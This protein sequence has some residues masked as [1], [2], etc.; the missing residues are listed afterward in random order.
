MKKRFGSRLI[1]M[2]LTLIMLFSVASVG[3]EAAAGDSDPVFE[4]TT[5]TIEGM[6]D[7]AAGYSWAGGENFAAAVNG[8]CAAISLA[9]GVVFSIIGGDGPSFEEV[10]FDYLQ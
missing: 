9:F 7:I 8:G 1:A 10:L 2:F 3:V 5:D 6:M 4:H